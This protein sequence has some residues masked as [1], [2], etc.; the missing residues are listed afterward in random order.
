MTLSARDRIVRSA[1]AAGAAAVLA[2]GCAGPP[3]LPGERGEPGTPASPA[4]S[5]SP[6]RGL[7]SAADGTDLAACADAV[8]EV[9]VAEG[10]EFPVSGPHGLERIVVERVAPGEVTVTGYGDG[11]GSM[12]SGTT[13]APFGDRPSIVLNGV[14]IAVL[15][16]AD[17]RAV[18]RFDY[19]EGALPVPWGF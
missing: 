19:E 4:R 7:P 14:T 12:V 16:V 9:E 13:G 5:S 8:C 15:A 3:R 10:D 1:A 11:G 18:V 17:G 6:S 2:C